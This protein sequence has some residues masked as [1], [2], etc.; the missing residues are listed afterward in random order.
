MYLH[1]IDE[2]RHVIAQD[3]FDHWQYKTLREQSG[4]L[5]SIETM[6]GRGWPETMQDLWA[7]LYKLNPK[8]L[9]P[10]PAGLEL[11]ETLLRQ[12]EAL[13]QWQELRKKTKLDEFN[14]AIATASVSDKLAASLPE[15]VKDAQSR[16]AWKAHR[17]ERFE[18]QE[19]VLDE[20]AATA[21]GERKAKLQAAARKARQ[22]AQDA[23]GEAN[24]ARKHLGHTLKAN[25]QAIRIALREAAEAAGQ[26][27]DEQGAMVE[28]WG[29]E[30]GQLTRV[31]AG[32][33]LAVADKLRNN[34][35]LKAIAEIAGR[36][37]AI[38]MMKQATKANHGRDEIVDIEIGKD[39]PRCLP[40]ELV[41]LA[42][43]DQQWDFFRR[44]HEGSLLMYRTEATEKVGRG[45]IV[46]CL[47]ESGSMAGSREVWS[48]GFALALM[49]VAQ[50]Q[51]RDFALVHFGARGE[52]TTHEFPASKHR[53]PT[54]ACMEFLGSG[55]TDFQSPLDEATKL[56]EGST[57]KKAD[58]V[59]ITDGGAEVKPEW[60][61]KFLAVKAAKEFKVYS[62]LI[63]SDEA[64]TVKKFSEGVA[65]LS[66]VENDREATEIFAA[67]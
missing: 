49:S 12:A 54:D 63:A 53:D 61:T 39:I 35:K 32:E 13:P 9:D 3:Q 27:V 65:V 59:F 64:E 37:K 10:V 8:H 6:G 56:I 34:H 11:S 17:Q 43:E 48:K 30:P 41:K 44:W 28:G 23:Q 2:P 51:R 46:L 42:D 60:L 62:V 55:G 15:E 47:D 21:K 19:Q 14:A 24:E 58:V 67:L 4:K 22:S 36:L 26:D 66:D 45:P 50:K 38:A 18:A 7:D 1:G 25:E 16:A 29:S 40:T 33:R 31:S 5:R 20:A 52:T 57:F